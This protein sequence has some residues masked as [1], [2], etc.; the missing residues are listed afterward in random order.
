MLMASRTAGGE[1]MVTITDE[2]QS[3]SVPDWV[4]DLEAFRRWTDSEDFPEDFE[5]WWLRGEVWIDV[6]KEQIFSHVL[7]KTR[8]TRVLDLLA[9]EQDRGIYLT[10]GVLLSNFAADIS[11]NPD[12]LFLSADTLASDRVRLIEG[13][14]GGY[15]ELQGSPDMVLEVLSASSVQKDTVVLKRAYYEAGVRE[16]W[17]VD[18][19]KEP[20]AFDLFRRTS[21]GFARTAKQEGWLKS[22]VFGKSF[23]LSARAGLQGHPDYSLEVK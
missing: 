17:L 18:A 5:V 23:R 19:R 4:T 9:V 3:I 12:G 20:I 7:V 13:K 22:A 21:K 8:F 6:S 14:G 16:Y 1:V 2:I 15:V 11:G 10:D